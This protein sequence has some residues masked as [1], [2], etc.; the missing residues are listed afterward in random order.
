MIL[1]MAMLAIL[2]LAMVNNGVCCIGGDH[3]NGGGAY[4]GDVGDEFDDVGERNGVNDDVDDDDVGVGELGDGRV[5]DDVNVGG[6]VGVGDDFCGNRIDHGDVRDDVDGDVDNLGK[7]IVVD[8]DIDDGDDDDNVVD[9]MCGNVD[10]LGG[11]HVGD[12]QVYCDNGDIGDDYVHECDDV[13]YDIDT[14]GGDHVDN[15]DVVEDVW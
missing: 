2:M 6:V 13:E 8:F 7:Y 5:H 3:V 11:A 14:F 9:D 12:D 1:A 15:N 10:G 4:S